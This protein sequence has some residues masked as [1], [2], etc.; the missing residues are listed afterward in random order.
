M[1]GLDVCAGSGIGPA[2]WKSLGGTTMCYVEKDPYCQKLLQARIRDGFICDAP[3][4][5]D[6]T[7]F[8]GREWNGLVDF[9]F[10]G[11]PCQPYSVAGKRRGAKDERDLWPDYLRIVGE[12]GPKFA[13]LENVSGFTDGSD[14]MC[15][16]IGEFSE[17]GYAVE[18]IPIQAA[19]I[20]APHE[21][22]RQWLIAYATRMD[23][24]SNP[25]GIGWRN[26]PGEQNQESR[27]RKPEGLFH[28]SFWAQ[29]AVP[30]VVGM[31]HGVADKLE[32]LRV[33]GNG[34]VPQVAVIPMGR[35]AQLLAAGA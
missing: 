3:I 11:I 18:G 30:S 14:G 9:I 33:C 26:W 17:I 35:V 13:L 4:W 28:A 31:D 12:V 16:V 15:R 7:T 22:E 6:L 24:S 34:W 20:G 8:D 1:N 5:D 19:E 29:V 23:K 25:E 2:V 27:E 10:G 32:Q 21:R